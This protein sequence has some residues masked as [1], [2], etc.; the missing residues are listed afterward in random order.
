M[1]SQ[2]L[3]WVVVSV[4]VGVVASAAT[5]TL[6]R[7]ASAA[8]VTPVACAPVSPLVA[9]MVQLKDQKCFVKSSGP[10][11]G[12]SAMYL[13]DGTPVLDCPGVAL[14]KFSMASW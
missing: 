5:L 10:T 4:C 7:W 14:Q 8:P 11:V 1:G 12:T 13:L 2:R 6:T 9:E 3:K